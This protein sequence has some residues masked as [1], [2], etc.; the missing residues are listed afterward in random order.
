MRPHLRAAVVERMPRPR[1]ARRPTMR[2]MSNT[3]T[4]SEAR[5][6]LTQIL[7]RVLAHDEVPTKRQGETV[8]VD[9]GNE[10]LRSCRGSRRHRASDEVPDLI[11][12]S[13]RVRLDPRGGLSEQRADLLVADVQAA[14]SKR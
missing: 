13:R 4:V 1:F 12:S 6:A 5:T 2:D 14:R 8:A 3:M 11:A 9:I 10:T 7:G